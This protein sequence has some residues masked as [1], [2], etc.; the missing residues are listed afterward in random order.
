MSNDI[1]PRQREVLAFVHESIFKRGFPPTATEVARRFGT[2]EISGGASD[3][4]VALE[5]KGYLER[6]G[7]TQRAL[8]ITD[9]GFA[10]LAVPTPAEQLSAVAIA[11]RYRGLLVRAWSALTQL[12]SRAPLL[13]EIQDELALSQKLC[14]AENEIDRSYDERA[15]P[16]RA[17]RG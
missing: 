14:A 4:L 3:V 10:E 7:S 6:E 1:T 12:D 9:A 13:A 8:R 16:S 5:K 11:E 15:R 2:S 17:W